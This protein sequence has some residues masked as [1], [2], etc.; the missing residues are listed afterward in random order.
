LEE[1]V[2]QI[3]PLIKEATQ[4]MQIAGQRTDG[5]SGLPSGF[6][7]LDKITSGWQNS[8]LI[9]IAARPA[10]KKTAFVLSMAK[11]M[12]VNFNIPVAVFSLEMSNVQ[13]VNRLIV[14]VCQIPREKIKTGELTP[15]EW[16]QLDYKIKDLFDAPIY[17]DD[18]PD[19]SIFELRTK[20]CHL[21]REHKVKCII[22]DYLQLMNASGMS[23]GSEEQELSVISRLLKELAK[24]L[25]IPII[26]LVRLNV[27][28]NEGEKKHPQLSDLRKSGVVELYADIVC[29]I[30]HSEII[31]A[32]H[33][34]GTVGN[35]LLSFNSEFGIFSE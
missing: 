17:I 18:S 20:A 10:M 29:F 16:E 12:A 13:L 19:L 33:R 23:F 35:V 27:E 7:A 3:N 24:E 28:N 31:I 6:K 9:I 26:A 21:V 11:N 32:K 1:S 30:H 22:I 4:M 34:N 14:N 5:L 2:T 15:N 25:N 8:D